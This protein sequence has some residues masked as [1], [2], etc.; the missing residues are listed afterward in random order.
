MDYIFPGC[1]DSVPED[2]VPEDSVPEDS[3]PEDSVPEDSVPEDS[4]PEDIYA[5]DQ[6]APFA[7]TREQLD[8]IGNDIDVTKYQGETEF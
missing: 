7:P 3:V 8:A 2:S 5:N 6:Y 1:E 4:V